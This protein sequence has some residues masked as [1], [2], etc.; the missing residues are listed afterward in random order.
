MFWRNNCI[1]KLNGKSLSVY[2]ELSSYTLCIAYAALPASD[3]G[4]RV[5]R[6]FASF[7]LIVFVRIRHPV[8]CRTVWARAAWEKTWPGCAGGHHLAS[9]L[10]AM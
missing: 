1:E 2:P 10:A 3:G 6:D 4:V 8:Q 7:E 5:L 9:L